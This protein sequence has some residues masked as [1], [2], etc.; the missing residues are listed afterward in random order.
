MPH[1]AGIRHTARWSL[2]SPSPPGNPGPLPL[3]RPPSPMPLRQ[4]R[5]SI[6]LP[7]PT[8]RQLQSEL[9]LIHGSQENLFLSLLKSQ[10]YVRI[11]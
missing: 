5:V 4:G 8:S 2:R 6:R 7:G 1:G 10:L 3:T 11:I 9:S